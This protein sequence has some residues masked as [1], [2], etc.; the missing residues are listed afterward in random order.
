MQKFIGNLKELIIY[1][2]LIFIF[3][4]VITDLKFRPDANGLM[5]IGRFCDAFH[6]ICVQALD[7]RVQMFPLIQRLKDNDFTP[8]FN[9]SQLIRRIIDTES[10]KT[11]EIYTIREYVN[12]DLDALR[13]K[14]CDLPNFLVN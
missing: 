3:K 6:E 1:F 12:A 13:R 4:T 8:I 14:Y 10:F 11:S 7:G 5:K 2:L 9:I